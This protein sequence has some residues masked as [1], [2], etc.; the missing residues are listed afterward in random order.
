MASILL[1][2][3]NH[4]I[5]SM[6]ANHRSQARHHHQQQ[7]WHLFMAFFLSTW[8]SSTL[9]RDAYAEDN[10]LHSEE[11]SHSS[12]VT[13][14]FRS[15]R[16]SSSDISSGQV[17]PYHMVFTQADVISRS[18]KKLLEDYQ[19][20]TLVQ[21]RYINT[22]SNIT[23]LVDT[24]DEDIL[25]GISGL[26]MGLDIHVAPLPILQ[27]P[28]AYKHSSSNPHPYEEFC[29]RRH[30]ALAVFASSNGI[31]SLL[32]H[33]LDLVVYQPFVTSFLVQFGLYSVG[34]FFTHWQLTM[35]QE[36]SQFVIALYELQ[37]DALATVIAEFGSE[38]RHSMNTS[39]WWPQH[40]E[41]KQ[42]SDMHAFNAFLALL[43]KEG[44]L[45]R[46]L[47]TT[48][49]AGGDAE[50]AGKG[51]DWD[52]PKDQIAY[53]DSY[54]P[55]LRAMPTL[56]TITRDCNVEDVRN[57]FEQVLA[58]V[59]VAASGEW[60][61]IK[62]PVVDSLLLVG[63]HFQGNCKDHMCEHMCPGLWQGHAATIDCCVQQAAN[64]TRRSFLEVD[65]GLTAGTVANFLL[66][67]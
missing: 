51:H 38:A 9:T 52:V 10:T 58:P 18:T 8:L 63:V 5:K 44:R 41:P 28:I 7:R 21:T 11:S 1:T 45:V 19:L 42:F 17:Q 2:N 39:L 20:L 15:L 55:F 12:N 66:R 13:Q 23:L 64:F 22:Y 32:H 65:G 47:R 62:V 36:W 26:L 46:D 34:S 67:L 59:L 43:E 35:L 3:R 40:L 14:S 4:C 61:Q 29:M 25:H 54:Q 60:V 33:D 27:K 57:I 48:T 37:D 31:H 53:I 50:G 49:P 56:R 24:Q 6:Q 30:V 16:S